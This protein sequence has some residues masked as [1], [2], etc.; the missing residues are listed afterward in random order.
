MQ[1]NVWTPKPLKL[2]SI[3]ENI[4]DNFDCEKVIWRGR[5]RGGVTRQNVNYIQKHESNLAGVFCK[6][7]DLSAGNISVVLK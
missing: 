2:E 3:I 5:E 1:K 7:T 6:K 4:F